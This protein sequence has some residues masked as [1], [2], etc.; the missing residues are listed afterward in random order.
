[1]AFLDDKIVLVAGGRGLLGSALV[2]AI[3]EHGGTAVSGDVLGEKGSP[4]ACG[5]ESIHMDVSS[6]SSVRE[7]I[8]SVAGEYGRLD[9]VVNCTYPRGQG[10]GRRMEDVGYDD[11]CGTVDL[12]LGGAFLMLQQGS[13]FFVRQ[14]WGNI[15]S[16]GSIYGVIAPRFAI[17]EGT[18]MT[19]PVEYSAIKAG[20]IHLTRYFAAYYKGR[21]IRFNC[22]SP[23]GIRSSSQ[24]ASFV[25]RYDRLAGTKGLLEPT[26]V[27]GTV[28]YLLSDL[29][30]FVQGQN[31]IVDDGW[32]L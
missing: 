23:G 4:Q 8:T 27:T 10:Y 18:D 14:G 21:R 17:Y 28:I 30:E 32:T 11:F 13:L 2:K 12:H 16:F 31:V 1:M 5:V 29:A 6:P 3:R 7:A 24:P 26:D 15:I 25:Q 20:I 22:V 19:M 9:A